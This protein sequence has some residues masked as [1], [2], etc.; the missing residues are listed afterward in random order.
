MKTI[1]VLAALAIPIPAQ[2]LG[3][4]ILAGPPDC[5]YPIAY[6]NTAGMVTMCHDPQDV[7]FVAVSLQALP[8]PVQITPALGYGW[9]FVDPASLVFL[10]PMQLYPQGSGPHHWRWEIHLLP[11][12]SPV[13]FT[14]QTLILHPNYLWTPPEA[15]RFTWL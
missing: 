10:E 11:T 9:V 7:V 6:G 15:Y 14:M 8:S 4:Q 2:Q 3:M 13:Q 5:T 12:W 1:L